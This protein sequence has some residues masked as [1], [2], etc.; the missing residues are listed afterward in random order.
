MFTLVFLTT[1]D[2]A[3]GIKLYLICSC[4]SY[5]KKLE[6][7]AAP[8]T[9]ICMGFKPYVV[10]EMYSPLLDEVERIISLTL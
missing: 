6:N 2:D 7:V 3:L 8:M 4:K 9:G 1:H 5:D 10:I